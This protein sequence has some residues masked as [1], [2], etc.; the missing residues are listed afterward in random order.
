MWTQQ[1]RQR[2]RSCL[3]KV[4]SFSGPCSD[5]LNGRFKKPRCCWMAFEICTN[6]GCLEIRRQ[7]RMTLAAQ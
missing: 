4:A 6:E 5:S 7:Q 3:Q 1:R 2:R